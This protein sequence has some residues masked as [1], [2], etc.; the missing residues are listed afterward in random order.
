MRRSRLPRFGV[1][2]ARRAAAAAGTRPASNG[3]GKPANGT[4]H[5]AMRQDA[6]RFHACNTPAERP[7]FAG[8]MPCAAAALTDILKKMG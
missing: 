8:E 3:A 4:R 1:A 2:D 6:A 7:L 5:V